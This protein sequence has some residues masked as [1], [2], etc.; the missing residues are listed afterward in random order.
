MSRPW[1]KTRLTVHSPKDLCK[2]Q[3]SESLVASKFSQILSQSAEMWSQKVW[4]APRHI[5]VEK[6]QA[7]CRP[8]E[9]GTTPTCSL[10]PAEKC[11]T[12]IWPWLCWWG[13]STVEGLPRGWGIA[14]R[15]AR[16]AQL[17]ERQM[18]LKFSE[19]PTRACFTSL[20]IR[21]E[22]GTQSKDLENLRVYARKSSRSQHLDASPLRRLAGLSYIFLCLCLP[23]PA[24]D[25]ALQQ[26]E[27]HRERRHSEMCENA[28]EMDPWITPL[29]PHS[30]L[31]LN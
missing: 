23:L 21:A 25:T 19:W 30:V 11:I 14:C 15:K 13:D 17:E 6:A 22:R 1:G 5:W 2:L 4:Y 12:S 28:V 18:R 16:D 27:Q 26:P 9:V 29:D 7:C 31:S 20:W 24:F 3:K 8:L 10:P